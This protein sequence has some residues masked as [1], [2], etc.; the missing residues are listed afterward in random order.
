MGDS[1]VY[2]ANRE[3]QWRRL[4]KDHTVLQGMIDCEVARPDTEYASLYGALA[5]VFADPEERRFRHPSRH[6]DA[7][8]GR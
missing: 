4:S 1:R 8:T 2:Q 3:G 5:H 7:G 6:G